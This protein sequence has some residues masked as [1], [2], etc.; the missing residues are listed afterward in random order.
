MREKKIRKSTGERALRGARRPA[1]H[2]KLKTG[3]TVTV[4]G[5]V[6]VRGEEERIPPERG[7]MQGRLKERLPFV[8]IG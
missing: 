5:F 4:E 3:G 2:E 7:E 1:P 6:E 8:S